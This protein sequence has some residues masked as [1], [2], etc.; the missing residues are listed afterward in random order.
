MEERVFACPVRP[1]TAGVLLPACDIVGI[2]GFQRSPP[3]FG[4]C[5]WSACIP[6]IRVMDLPCRDRAFWPWGAAWVVSV[7]VSQLLSQHERSDLDLFG[8]VS[9][10]VSSHPV[11]RDRRRMRAVVGVYHR[12]FDLHQA[13]SVCVRAS[14]GHPPGLEFYNRENEIGW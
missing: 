4:E 3:K 10:V 11:E 14:A 9:A 8:C 13:T 12:G 2:S 7:R 1:V 5:S 6:Q